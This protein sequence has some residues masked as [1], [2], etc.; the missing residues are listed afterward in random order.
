MF[1]FRAAGSF[2]FFFLCFMFGLGFPLGVLSESEV[3]QVLFSQRAQ[4]PLLK[5]YTSSCKGGLMSRFKVYCSVNGYWAPR[6]NCSF[7]GL[8]GLCKGLHSGC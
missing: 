5:V 7:I 6:L 3:V 4:C 1:H 2:S 8:Y